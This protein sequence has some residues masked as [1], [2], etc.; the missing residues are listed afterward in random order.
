V[1][2]IPTFSSPSDTLFVEQTAH[3]VLPRAIGILQAKG[4]KLVTVAECL[5]V[6]PYQSVSAP[7]TVNLSAIITFLNSRV[8]F[9]DHGRAIENSLRLPPQ[10]AGE[11]PPLDAST[12]S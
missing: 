12:F 1:I 4:Y 2:L 5:G 10:A 8:V 7:Q 11:D 6:E 3:V 9:R